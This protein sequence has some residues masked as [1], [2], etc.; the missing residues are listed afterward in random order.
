[1]WC[2]CKRIKK[3]FLCSLLQ[4]EQIS[5][6]CDNVC[7]SLRNERKEAQEA[8]IAKKLEEE[9]L[10]NREEIEKFEKKFK[11]RRKRKDKYENSKQSQENARNKYCNTWILAIVI[12]IMG[13]IMVYITIPDLSILGLS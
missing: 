11:P 7:E 3:D 13:I 2:K 5:V 4:K 10:R 1:M 8:M 9:E 12:S 6:E